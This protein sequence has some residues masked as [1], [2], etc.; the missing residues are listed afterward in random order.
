AVLASFSLPAAAE[1]IAI[2]HV[3]VVNTATGTLQRDAT[4]VIHGTRSVSVGA[5]GSPHAGSSIVD[6]RG[7]FLIPGLWDMHAH[8]SWCTA[9]A[10]PLL[11]A[12]GV[13]GVRDLGGRL[14]EL[15]DWRSRIDAGVL[16][17]P[18]II[19]VGP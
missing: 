13:T 14:V 1:P 15:D 4:V 16:T 18:R 6:G 11:I 7:K 9:S 2:T 5:T 17:G 19:R 10:L 12:N 3:A 8:L